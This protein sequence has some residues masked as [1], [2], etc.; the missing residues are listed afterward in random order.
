[1]MQELGW[2]RT[3]RYSDG[4]WRELRWAPEGLDSGPLTSRVELCNHV[5]RSLHSRGIVNGV[6]AEGTFWE[7]KWQ[8]GLRR[9]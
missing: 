5:D 6:R 7:V 8:W 3:R 9:R 1:M 2:P 4:Q